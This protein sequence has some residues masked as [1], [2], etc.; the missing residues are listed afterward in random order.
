M[1]GYPF[2]IADYEWS[3]PS[4]LATELQEVRHYGGPEILG[5]LQQ[6]PFCGFPSEP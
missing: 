5:C 2:V 1:I 3:A 6:L 4:V